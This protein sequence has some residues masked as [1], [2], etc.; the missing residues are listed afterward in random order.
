MKFEEDY[1]SSGNIHDSVEPVIV[2]FDC[3]DEDELFHDSDE[4]KNEIYEFLCIII[5]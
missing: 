5:H 1:W 4:D 2:T 3:D